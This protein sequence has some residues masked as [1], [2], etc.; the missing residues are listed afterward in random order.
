MNGDAGVDRPARSH[1][2]ALWPEWAHIEDKSETPWQAAL[3]AAGNVLIAHLPRAATISCSNLGFVFSD[4][5]MNATR[6][7][8]LPAR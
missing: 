2:L 3:A 1:H 7:Y 4:S 6:H 5:G 8:V